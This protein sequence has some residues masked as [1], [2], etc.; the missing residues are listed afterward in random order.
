QAKL[1]AHQ[2]EQHKQRKPRDNARQDQRQQHQPPEQRLAGKLRPVESQRCRN[3]KRQRDRHRR[4]RH[5]QAVQ[6]RIPDRPVREQDAIPIE[7]EVMRWKSAYALSIERIENENRNRQ[8]KER[9]HCRRMRQQPP[10]ARGIARVTAHEKLHFFS[11][12]SERKSRPTTITSMPS[13]IAAPRGHWQEEPNK[14]T[15]KFEIMLH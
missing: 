6:H 15:T 1:R 12:R 14:R 9:K 13:E 4:E 5:L 7:R 11:S 10:R 3:P 8:I 2:V